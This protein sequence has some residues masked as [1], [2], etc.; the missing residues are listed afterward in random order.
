ME[1]TEKVITELFNAVLARSLEL[2]GEYVP[3]MLTVFQPERAVYVSNTDDEI[4]LAQ[5]RYIVELLEQRIP[6]QPVTTCDPEETADNLAVEVFAAAMKARMKEKREAGYSGWRELGSDA[7]WSGLYFGYLDDRVVDVANYAMMLFHRVGV[8]KKPTK[9]YGLEYLKRSR[10]QL[11]LAER[12]AQVEGPA[13]IVRNQ[14]E[15]DWAQI[16]GDEE[17]AF[18]IACGAMKEGGK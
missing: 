2:N 12:V 9:G 8:V 18:C 6:D 7:L 13:K 3:A 14:C 10:Q 15:H 1:I 16:Q 11:S 5:L 17:A 4:T